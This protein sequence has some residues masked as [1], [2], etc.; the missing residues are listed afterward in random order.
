MLDL[1][2]IESKLPKELQEAVAFNP[3]EDYDNEFITMDD[4]EDSKKEKK[5][6][7]V[8]EFVS[9]NSLDESSYLE[10]YD[11]YINTIIESQRIISEYNKMILD[12]SYI[13]EDSNLQDE[14]KFKWN[15]VIKFA[16][17]EVKKFNINIDKTLVR[18]QQFLKLYKN[19]LLNNKWRADQNYVYNGDYKV[20]ID[21]CL[22]SRLPEFN[23]EVYGP[24]I[25]EEGYEAAI[26]RMM[27]GKAFNIDTKEDNNLQNQ[28]R[29]FFLA[30]DRGQSNGTFA[31]LNPT[32]IYNFCN[33]PNNIISNL[34]TDLETIRRSENAIVIAVDKIMRS[35]GEDPNKLENPIR[36]AQP[37]NTATPNTGINTPTG[38]TTT[39]VNASAIIDANGHWIIQED[40]NN[41]DLN[42]NLKVST[43]VLT[44]TQPNQNNTENP[45]E[46]IKSTTTQQDIDNIINKWSVL[47]KAFIMGKIMALQKI[48][49]DYMMILQLAARGLQN[50]PMYNTNNN[51]QQN[52]NYNIN[53]Q[54]QNNQP[55]NNIR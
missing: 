45:P 41:K 11:N 37:Q 16:T 52:V 19:I 39:N 8:D 54:Q 49:K 50:K 18:S 29:R 38:N 27:A 4:G 36:N 44:N 14:A 42:T 51:Q 46:K 33:N 23:Y 21:R 10:V 3:N 47:N 13:L 20:A 6:K 40:T 12:E 31:E 48:S 55:N 15:K 53:Q 35:K 9:T 25:R 22:N 7:Y 26:K 24:S 17:D 43:T 1:K 2:Y 34:N 5:E 32:E 30:L 28:F